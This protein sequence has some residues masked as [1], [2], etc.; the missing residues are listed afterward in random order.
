MANTND[1]REVIH[2]IGDQL[3]KKATANL[4]SQAYDSGWPTELSRKLTV[5]HL[6]E[7]QF[8]VTYPEDLE[9]QILDQEAGTQDSPAN[10]VIRTFMNRFTDSTSHY[11]DMLA[12]VIN[13]WQV[14]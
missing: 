1:L 3:S 7:G 14:F 13:K 9:D 6:G 12:S 5:T 11:D 4:R 10:P 8:K 2:Q